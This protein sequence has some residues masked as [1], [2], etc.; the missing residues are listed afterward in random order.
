MS[1]FGLSSICSSLMYDIL[2]GL[3]FWI[4]IL[5]L[6][7]SL[8]INF[9]K[10]LHIFVLSQHLQYEKASTRSLIPDYAQF[11]CFPSKFVILSYIFHLVD[12]KKSEK[13]KNIKKITIYMNI[14]MIIPY[15]LS[16]V[17]EFDNVAL[18]WQLF[19]CLPAKLTK[20]CKKN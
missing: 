8:S 2:R 9:W 17:P 10:S 1:N 4:T 20:N 18:F 7:K 5:M 13:T 11:I 3:Y 19:I 12:S 15:N 16:C 6:R 14:G